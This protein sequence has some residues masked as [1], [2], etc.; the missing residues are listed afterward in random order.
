MSCN[1]YFAIV[2]RTNTLLYE[3]QFFNV[4]K[5]PEGDSLFFKQ[6]VANAAL[7]MVEEF[8]WR[9]KNMFL[10]CVDRYEQWFVS[11]FVTPSLAKFVLVYDRMNEQEIRH[12]FAE[13][14]E[15]FIKYTM[16]PF[17]ED[18]AKIDSERFAEKVRIYGRKYLYD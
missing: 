10:R 13:V 1:Y 4:K 2:S 12:F 16:N 3:T 14:L 15:M 6:L 7:D 8:Q 18:G 9:T 17:Y 11:A 5:Q